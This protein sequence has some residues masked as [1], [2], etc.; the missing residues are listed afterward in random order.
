MTDLQQ[1]DGVAALEELTRGVAHDLNNLL[2][3]M[4]TCAGSIAGA[5]DVDQGVR[6]EAGLII[7]AAERAGRLTRQLLTVEPTARRAVDLNAVIGEMLDLL[8]R[9]VG[10]GIRIVLATAAESPIVSLDRDRVERVVMNL[11]LNARDAMQE[12]GTLTIRTGV[13]QLGESSPLLRRGMR[14]GV[15][16]TLS[17]SDTGNGMTP[18]VADRAFDPFFTTKPEGQTSG[19]GLAIVSGIVLDIGGT[20]HLRSETRLGTTVTAYLPV[21]EAA[22]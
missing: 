1:V 2:T 22:R 14:A 19:L 20:V 18:D 15:H 6:S 13:A 9:T 4:L 5:D 3:V 17:V 10:A 12:G 11:A 21:A 8:T 7:E 16:A